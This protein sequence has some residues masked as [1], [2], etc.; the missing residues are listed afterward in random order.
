MLPGRQGPVA[1]TYDDML[2]CEHEFA[3]DVDKLVID[4]PAP[5]IADKDGKYPIPQPGINV[6]T[7]YAVPKKN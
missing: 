4:G 2:A 6:R 7:E 5:I 3:P 1:L